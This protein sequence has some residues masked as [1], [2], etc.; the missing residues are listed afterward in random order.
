[1]GDT[2]M[3]GGKDGSLRSAG[4]GR[5][6]APARRRSRPRRGGWLLVAL[7]LALPAAGGAQAG[8]GGN[9]PGARF[10]ALEQRMLQAD[11]V[12]LDF[13]VTAEGA[14]VIAIEGTLRRAADGALT[15][16]ARGEFGG[17]PVDLLLRTDGDTYT[18]GNGPEP[19]TAPV[20]PALWEAVALGFTRMGILHNLARLTG[21]AP[22]D[23]AEGGAGQWV[24]VDGFEDAPRGVAFDITVAGQPSG[25]ATLEMDAAGRPTVRRQT[26]QFPNGEMRVVERYSG[27][28]LG[29]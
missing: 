16:Q 9:D 12:S 21:N 13:R 7:S 4:T 15:I 19:A 1:M 14:A 29:A 11:A 23:H 2:A 27:V 6:G 8:A 26:V 18:F 24:V 28:S 22:P 20:P 10:A 3:K 25:S 17:R 5:P